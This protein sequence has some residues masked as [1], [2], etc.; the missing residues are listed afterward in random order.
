M[1]ITSIKFYL[2]LLNK[3]HPY[4]NGNGVTFKIILAIYAKVIKLIEE[5]ENIKK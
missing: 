1:E 2:I 4:Y 5:I 3:A